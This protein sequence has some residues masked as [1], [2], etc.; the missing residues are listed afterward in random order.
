MTL[1][2]FILH[3]FHLYGRRNRLFL[4]D[5]VH[6]IVFLDIAMGDLQDGVRKGADRAF[7][8][9][10]LA[11]VFARIICVADYFGNLPLV[12][13]LCGKYPQEG[14]SYCHH[15]SCDCPEQRLDY[16]LESKP[17]EI[18]FNWSLKEWCEHF[19][20]VYG[21]RNRSRSINDV[22]SRLFKE[23]A[24]LLI[25]AMKLP[26]G[27]GKAKIKEIEEEF[28]KELADALAWTIAAANMLAINLEVE[29]TKRYGEVCW[30]CKICPCD[31]TLFSMEPVK[32]PQNN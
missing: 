32:W 11:R 10:M 19:N 6:R 22:L 31:C 5:L 14:C 27:F 9:T 21:E 1:N 23:I 4:P 2:D 24:E 15:L 18:Q 8:G 16:V 26:G 25:L 29:V 12:E 17:S 20:M 30:N 7:L 28:A 3:L 13:M